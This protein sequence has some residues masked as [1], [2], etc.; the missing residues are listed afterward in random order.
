MAW[1]HPEATAGLIFKPPSRV[2]MLRTMAAIKLNHSAAHMMLR[3]TFA[4]WRATSSKRTGN[5]GDFKE[6][7]ANKKPPRDESVMANCKVCYARC[8]T[9]RCRPFAAHLCSLQAE[10]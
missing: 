2:L 4:L 6:W 5:T 8:F 7:L 1:S 9:D 10:R 3:F